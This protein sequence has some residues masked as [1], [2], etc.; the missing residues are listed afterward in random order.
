MSPVLL[1]ANHSLGISNGQSVQVWSNSVQQWI[2]D[3]R[4]LEVSAQGIMVEFNAG[5]QRKLIPAEQIHQNILAQ[6]PV[7]SSL[8]SWRV[9]FSGNLG[10]R[11]MPHAFEAQIPGAVLHSGEVFNVT[12]ELQ[13]V[14]GVLFLKLADGRGWVFDS[15]AGEGSVCMREEQHI[16]QLPSRTACEDAFVTGD[17]V[18]VWSNSAQT[19]FNDGSITAISGEGITVKCNSGQFSKTIPHPQASAFLK[20]TAVRL[21]KETPGNF[22]HIWND[23]AAMVGGHTSAPCPTHRQPLGTVRVPRIM[24]VQPL[25]TVS[26]GPGCNTPDLDAEALDDT[27]PLGQ[28]TSATTHT[29]APCCAGYQPLDTVCVPIMEVQPLGIVNC[30]PENYTPGPD[31]EAID[32]TRPL[33]QYTSATT[34]GASLLDE[35]RTLV[36]GA[37][38]R[39]QGFPGPNLQIHRRP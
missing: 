25:G 4:V 27:R 5:S 1:A 28:C 13:G 26:W 23:A 24:G 19:W 31:N 8:S 34:G 6:P 15:W 22:N 32:A 35:T 11:S 10:I 7:T 12:Q 17:A 29:S 21:P 20:R 36:M 37:G 33:C 14:D 38:V 16:E 9:T 3:G 30:G 39:P 2:V 18:F